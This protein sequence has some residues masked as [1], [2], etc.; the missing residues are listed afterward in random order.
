MRAFFKQ[1]FLGLPAIMLAAAF[2]T[3]CSRQ[4]IG[5][6]G[7]MTEKV[8]ISANQPGDELQKKYP[9]RF[10]LSDHPSG[11]RFYAAQWP[12]D[13]RGTIEVG[14]QGQ[15]FT[16]RYALSATGNYS[17]AFPGENIIEWD[18][19]TGMDSSSIIG[20]DEARR[21]FMALLQDIRKAGWKRYVDQGFPRLAGT[22]AIRYASLTSPVYGLDPDYQPTLDEWMKLP[23]RALWKFWSNQGYLSLALSRDPNRVDVNQPGAYFIEVVLLGENEQFRKM[24][25]P[26]RRA[27][28]KDALPEELKLLAQD[29]QSAEDVLRAQGIKIEET[30]QDPPVP[31][32]LTSK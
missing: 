21:R 19:N 13:D 26:A 10:T 16:L 18:V 22:D 11:A 31:E 15:A 8:S 25:G 24:V 4:P 7:K 5:E 14:R 2:I 1:V 12:S 27:Q 29:R 23:G 30:Y 17:S 6:N 20:H 32:Q 9:D 28:W 3:G